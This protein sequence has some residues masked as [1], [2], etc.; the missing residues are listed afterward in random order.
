MWILNNFKSYFRLMYSHL[1]MPSSFKA[2]WVLSISS[3]LLPASPLLISLT[4]PIQTN[5]IQTVFVRTWKNKAK[6]I[7]SL[8]YN[9]HLCEMIFIQLKVSYTINMEVLSNRLFRFSFKYM[10]IAQPAF[11]V[12]QYYKNNTLF[13]LYS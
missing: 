5:K 10:A 2:I 1:R 11:A 9:F 7:F 12:W 13:S 4:I 6:Y 3:K 8:I